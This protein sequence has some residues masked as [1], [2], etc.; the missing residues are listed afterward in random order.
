MQNW[1]GGEFSV[2]SGRGLIEATGLGKGCKVCKGFPWHRAA[3]SLKPGRTRRSA[4]GSA[5]FPWHRAAASLKPDLPAGEDRAGRRRFPW[6]R[7]AASL[8]P[9]R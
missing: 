8:K 4:P 1:D 6:H 7:A 9:D 2:A 3:A 5:G